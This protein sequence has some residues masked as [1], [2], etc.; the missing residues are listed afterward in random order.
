[1][2]YFQ[3]YLVYKELTFQFPN[4]VFVTNQ[5]ADKTSKNSEAFGFSFVFFWF[6]FTSYTSIIRLPAADR[7]YGAANDGNI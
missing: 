3:V 2:T 4:K 5:R 1:M 6:N 7:V